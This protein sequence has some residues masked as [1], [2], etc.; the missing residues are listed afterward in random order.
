MKD[1][2]SQARVHYGEGI[3][4]LFKIPFVVAESGFMER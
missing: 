2:V 1:C 4:L 3:K